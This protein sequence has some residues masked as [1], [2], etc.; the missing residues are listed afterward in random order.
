M[1]E[2]EYF[3]ERRQVEA[4]IEQLHQE[5]ATT[6]AIEAAEEVLDGL[7]DL[8]PPQL[9]L[10]WDN[11]NIRTKHR[12]ER[13]GDQYSS[14]NLDWMASLWIQD[15]IDSNHMDHSEGVAVK[16]VENLSIKDMVP[17]E[18]EKDYIFMAMVHY[19]SYRLVERHPVLF[20]SLNRCIK[21]NRSHQF[22][23]EMNGASRE[24]TGDLFTQSES[25]TEDLI[26]MMSKFQKNVHRFADTNGDEHCYEKKIVSGD[27]KTEKNRHYGILR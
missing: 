5:G 8:C 3:D 1:K 16:D 9:Q 22:Q 4:R 13:K 6:D 23:Q 20:K 7:L 2:E 27:N 15:R 21:S 19:F 25:R 10:V 24:F 12:F 17:S 26:T 11:L 18:K 14:S